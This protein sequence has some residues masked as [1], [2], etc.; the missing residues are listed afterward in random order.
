MK[1]AY[2]TLIGAPLVRAAA[3]AS[4]MLGAACDDD[5]GNLV[6][7]DAALGT[8]ND[9]SAANLDTAVASDA[10]ATD[11][12]AP[13]VDS[14][15]DVMPLAPGAIPQR[16]YLKPSDSPFA[17]IDFTYFHLED[18]E[19]HMLNTPGLSSQGQL[20]S[21]FGAGVIDSVDAD[22]G[23][24]T[25]NKCIKAVGTCDAW[26]G[27]G[28]LRFSFDAQVLGGLPTH[29]GLIWTDGG[30]TVS[31]EAF[32]PDGESIYKLGP[33]SE[34][35]FPDDTI[36]SSTMEDRFFGAFAPGGISAVVISNT[37]GGVEADHVQYGRAR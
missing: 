24:P 34:P 20:S 10:G 29:V 17:G 30:G 35:G 13:T 28:T 5:S 9:G 37:A 22:D 31:F 32:G 23:N 19:D 27:G 16:P 11:G 15:P 2:R 4:L 25:D 7:S 1:M 26:W 33:V 6:S 18:F 8:S 14:G 12:A 21:S 3:L 36:A